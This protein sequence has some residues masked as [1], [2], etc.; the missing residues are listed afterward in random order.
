VGKRAQKAATPKLDVPQDAMLTVAMA[1]YGQCPMVFALAL[2]QA[3]K[4]LPVPARLDHETSCYVHR[5][6]NMLLDRAMNSEATHLMFLDTD[7]IFPVSGI[8]QLLAARK[9]IIGGAYN[10]KAPPR[11]EG[12]K[13]VTTT[14]VKALPE[15]YEGTHD[16]WIMNR[17][18]PFECAGLP[19]GFMLI[20]LRVL[21]GVEP[22]PYQ[23]ANTLESRPGP[24]AWFDFEE[25]DGT[26]VGEDIYFCNYVRSQGVPLWCD[27]TIKLGHI[28]PNVF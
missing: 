7:I 18:A 9:P 15:D 10:L 4:F 20:D 12:D 5:N 6:R 13:L 28:G 25:R 3:M 21:R 26:F 2:A 22:P 14:T 17:S 23:G 19:T 1:D 24:R 8:P 11:K 27:P 16:N